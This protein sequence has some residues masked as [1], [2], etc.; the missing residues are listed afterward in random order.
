MKDPIQLEY[1]LNEELW[2]QFFAAHHQR[3]GFFRLRYGYG[4]LLL[5]AGAYLAGGPPAKPWL[6]GGFVLSGLY[7]ILSMQLLILKSL[8]AA[9]KGPLFSARLAVSIGPQGLVVQAG[10]HRS[11]RPWNAVR[12]YCLVAPGIMIYLDKNAFFFIPK[13]ALNATTA[14]LLQRCFEQCGLQKL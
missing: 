2:R 6:G 14:G 7:C 5:L 8:S 9:R 4:L 10:R 13:Q 1:T 3:Q 12:G 11:E